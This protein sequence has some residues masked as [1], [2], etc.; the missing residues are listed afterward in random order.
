[1]TFQERVYD[2]THD[3]DP[4]HVLHIEEGQDGNLHIIALDDTQAAT[5]RLGTTE[6]R[7]LRLAITRWEKAQ[8]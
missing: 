5:V 7:K 3:Y 2:T 6:A 8:S 4:E 1:M